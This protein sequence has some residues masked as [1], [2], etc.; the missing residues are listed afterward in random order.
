MNSLDCMNSFIYYQ[1]LISRIMSSWN[2]EE[3]GSGKE[4]GH[5]YRKR[6]HVDCQ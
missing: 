3:T 4:Y 6:F 1:M 2:F 5:P